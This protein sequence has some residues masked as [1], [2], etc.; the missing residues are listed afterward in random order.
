MSKELEVAHP[1]ASDPASDNISSLKRRFIELRGR[2]SK[3]AGTIRSILALLSSNLF[4]SVLAAIGGLLVARFIGPEI[5]GSFRVYTIPLTYLMFFQLGTFDGLGR[6]IPFYIGKGLP[7]KIDGLAA[8]GGAFIICIS[9]ACS[10]GFVVCAVYSA[11]HHDLY[12]VF[13]WLSQVLCCWGIFYGG[14]L[15]STYRTLHHFVT[16][17]R[18]QMTQTILTFGLVFSLPFLGF[19]GLSARSAFPQLLAVWLY[20]R[21]RP[22]KVRYRFDI[23]ALKEL[24]GIGLP[25]NVWGSLYTSFWAASENALVLSLGGVTSLGLFAVATVIGGAVNS[26]TMAVW[27]VLAPRIITAYARDG[28]M[29]NVN[30]WMLWVTSGLT[31]FMILLAITGSFL[32]DL[33]VPH[34]IPKYVAGIAAMKVC[35]WFP[36]VQAAL[37]PIN[38]L[39]ATGRHWLYGRNVIAGLI[40]FPIAT[41]L[42]LPTMGGLLAVV[43]GSL[44]GRIARAVVVY[45]DLASLTRSEA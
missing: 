41:Y 33:L 10:L 15:T 1:T 44:L 4:S 14:F 27:Q 16:L 45:L 37:L 11:F 17:A 35:L 29:R 36:V 18:I 23:P 42:L 7:E 26:L 6:Q 25:F 2:I 3:S 24:I 28:S 9:I 40:V 5:N 34:F 22:L 8:T 43:M 32:L 12:G 20:H 39:F 31:G 30:A 19:Y 13:G 21:N 38:A